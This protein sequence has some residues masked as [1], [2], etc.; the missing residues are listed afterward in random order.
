MA[1]IALYANNV[2]LMPELLQGMK[3]SVSVFNSGLSTL[4][5]KALR[6]NQNICNLDDVTSTIQKTLQIQDD[7]IA[8]LDTL[9]KNIEAFVGSTVLIDNNVADIINQ[10]KDIFYNTYEYLKPNCEKNTWENIK[11]SITNCVEWCLDTWNT[12]IET[13]KTT[14]IA[15][16]DTI[17]TAV[18]NAL[19]DPLIHIVSLA[20]AAMEVGW[21]V[22]TQVTSSI[23]A[24]VAFCFLSIWLDGESNADE[25]NHEWGHGVQQSIMGPLRYLTLIGIPSNGMWNSAKE[26]Y[27]QPW[28]I[29]ADMF[30]GVSRVEH[31]QEYIERGWRYFWAAKYPYRFNR[32][33]E[34]LDAWD[35]IH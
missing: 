33:N 20:I 16:G 5:T 17:L 35:N 24:Y 31:T 14:L 22:L 1:T 8:S 32:N 34:F 19:I 2:N 7:K 28:E 23:F 27:N 21:G 15:I 29:N 9:N 26:Y 4:K 3:Q 13:I 18:Y 10:S 6:V 12:V 11:D 30:G 25:I